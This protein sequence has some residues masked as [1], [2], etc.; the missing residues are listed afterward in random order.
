VVSVEGGDRV[1]L[2]LSEVQK[3]T[4][5]GTLRRLLEEILFNKALTR[6][7]VVA[8]DDAQLLVPQIMHVDG[9]RIRLLNAVRQAAKG[10]PSAFIISGSGESLE[11]AFG[12]G[13]YRSSGVGKSDSAVEML[14]LGRYQY[15]KPVDVMKLLGT[16]L[17]IDCGDVRTESVMDYLGYVLQGRAKVAA[18][19][20]AR[21]L[22]PVHLAGLPVS[23][24]V[25]RVVQCAVYVHAGAGA[26]A[27]GDGDSVGELAPLGVGSPAH[28]HHAGKPLHR[29]RCS[30]THAS[31]E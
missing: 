14:V 30:F 4:D 26:T 22:T 7:V 10:I 5:P 11:T 27:I 29:G 2:M 28:A 20:V 13:L 23:V 6:R 25:H 15:L 31:D 1:S 9:W 8:L 18:N 3:I 17:N 16:V 12:D 21:L 19:F 24:A